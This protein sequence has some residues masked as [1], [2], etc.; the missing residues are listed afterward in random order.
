[1]TA[2]S[3]PLG[4]RKIPQGPEGRPF[5][6]SAQPFRRRVRLR[7]PSTVTDAPGLLIL[8]FLPGGPRRVAG[9]PVKVR[10]DAGQD[11]EHTRAV[12]PDEFPLGIGLRSQVDDDL[13]ASLETLHPLPAP[14]ESVQLIS[15]VG[16]QGR[17]GLGGLG[18]L[19]G[20]VGQALSPPLAEPAGDLA[21]PLRAKQLV[22]PTRARPP[23]RRDLA[24][25]QPRA[26][27]FDDGPDALL[28][29]FS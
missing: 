10:D 25:G 21:G 27:G 23:G 22:N 5:F 15:E 16:S 26:M 17:L 20:M 13:F 6:P 8:G 19:T 12:E 3:A 11:A 4:G 9:R 2:R 14:A 28:P 18:L 7:Q 29:G 1:M 24:D